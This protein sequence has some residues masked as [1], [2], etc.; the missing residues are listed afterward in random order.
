MAFGLFLNFEK[1]S[2]EIIENEIKQMTDDNALYYNDEEAFDEINEEKLLPNLYH[3]SITATFIVN[4]Y[5]TALNTILG[6][7]LGCIEQKILEAHQSL[8]L[9]IICTLYGVDLI[10]VK[11]H[12]SYA[13]LQDI[14]KVRNDIT[15]FKSNEIFEGTFIPISATLPK[16]TSKLPIAEI[17]TKTF[18]EKAYNGVLDFMEMLCQKCGLMMCKECEVLDCDGRDEKCEFIIKVTSYDE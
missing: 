8:K 7:R 6:R 2:L 12:T 1:L 16:G 17:F 14:I 4:L 9:Q 18:M 15:H 3:G 13:I 11:G 10:G 5:E